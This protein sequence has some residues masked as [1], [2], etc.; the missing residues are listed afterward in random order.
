MSF[1]ICCSSN[2]KSNNITTTI[3]S[4]RNTNNPNIS[5][6]NSN[7]NNNN[8]KNYKYPNPDNNHN[9]NMETPIKTKID[10]SSN[11]GG[12]IP[13]PSSRQ[14][15]KIINLKDNIK[16]DKDL[17]SEKDIALEEKSNR[18]QFDYTAE[19]ENNPVNNE[20]NQEKINTN[21]Q[22]VNNTDNIINTN[23]NTNTNTNNPNKENTSTN[24]PTKN[25][26]NKN[27]PNN[28]PKNHHISADFN[29]S[30]ISN[31]SKRLDEDNGYNVINTNI[32]HN[33]N[34]NTN[35]LA[36]NN[37]NSKEEILESFLKEIGNNEE[38]VNDE[39]IN[40][41]KLNDFK[42][43]EFDEAV[44]K[45][46]PYSHRNKY[47]VKVP[48]TNDLFSFNDVKSNTNNLHIL[49]KKGFDN[50]HFSNSINNNSNFSRN[51]NSNHNSN[52]NLNNNI[53]R[54]SDNINSINS[55]N[56]KVSPFQTS[57]NDD[58]V[59]KVASS[60]E[61][62]SSTRNKNHNIN[63]NMNMNEDH[64]NRDSTTPIQ[65]DIN[66]INNNLNT[67]NLKDKSIIIE[68]NSNINNL[69]NYSVVSS[70]INKDVKS[71]NMNIKDC[72][73][74]GV[75]TDHI[76]NININTTK[77]SIPANSNDYEE[78]STTNKLITVKGGEGI[79]TP[80]KQSSNITN[81]T[82]MTNHTTHTNNTNTNNTNFTK[83]QINNIILQNI[84]TNNNHIS[85]STST[86]KTGVNSNYNNNS[87][88][89]NSS[90]N[91]PSTTYPTAPIKSILHQSNI[92]N[93]QNNETN[94]NNSNSNS[95]SL[96]QIKV[97]GNSTKKKVNILASNLPNTT[98]SN[99]LEFNKK[100]TNKSINNKT[101]SISRI[102]EEDYCDEENCNVDDTECNQSVVSSNVLT[103]LNTPR[104]S[105]LYNIKTE[106]NTSFHQSM[107]SSSRLDTLNQ[108]MITQSF[109]E[110]ITSQKIIDEDEFNRSRSSFGFRITTP[111]NLAGDN[112]N[113][114]QFQ[115]NNNTAGG[116][117]GG[118]PSSSNSQSSFNFTSYIPGVRDMQD[119]LT[120]KEKELKTLNEKI[121]KIVRDLQRLEEENKK[122]DR[123]IDKE[124]AEGERLRHLLNYL[125]FTTG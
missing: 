98:N 99:K 18:K 68:N 54:Q 95:N 62:S 60:Q 90:N 125:M 30:V 72:E 21:K 55:M 59:N 57:T 46:T 81:Q 20:E 83:Q 26:S 8:N 88:T 96:Q 15:N 101:R 25:L 37:Q 111:K 93:N 14:I 69:N 41:G 102:N 118:L 51:S 115:N 92:N 35:N 84:N 122:Y 63:M 117:G 19:N 112:S 121:T 27:S 82:N 29:K 123:K 6:D 12:S 52:N 66:N 7:H 45:Q 49:Q 32:P 94:T 50:L 119:K 108:M 47:Q 56:R 65:T 67:N 28:H 109:N 79:R 116:S 71:S 11:Q 73:F 75:S 106:N 89:N 36:N 70:I 80:T 77:T 64:T 53:L 86:S 85:I 1:F 4:T 38:E 110:D 34:T 40:I 100:L 104:T 10:N 23:T 113:S 13:I 48:E 33:S 31:I 5:V 24:N 124:E 3:K 22:A 58:N 87:I 16:Y 103:H 114:N 2:K 97:I 105:G 74:K 43:N 44:N 120:K 91:P 39:K 107:D 61:F 78:K 42:I 17:L 76:I 9:N